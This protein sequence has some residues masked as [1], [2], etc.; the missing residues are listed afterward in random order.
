MHWVV[1]LTTVQ[2]AELACASMAVLVRFF[3]LLNAWL[4]GHYIAAVIGLSS[5]IYPK[6]APCGFLMFLGAMH[7]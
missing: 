2:Y 7:V 3:L 6:A 1:G 5:W 4:A